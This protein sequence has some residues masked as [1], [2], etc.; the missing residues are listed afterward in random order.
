[1]EGRS[2]AWWDEFFADRSKR[3]PFFVEWP[4]ENLVGWFEGG[5][6]LASVRTSYGP[7]WRRRRTPLDGVEG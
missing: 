5:R 3:C 4:D 1:L 7:C 2:K 6:G